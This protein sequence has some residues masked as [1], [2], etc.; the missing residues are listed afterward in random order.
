MCERVAGRRGLPARDPAARNH[1]TREHQAAFRWATRERRTGYDGE[2]TR[3][4]PDTRRRRRRLG[5]GLRDS[6]CRRSAAAGAQRPHLPDRLTGR[7]RGRAPLRAAHRAVTHFDPAPQGALNGLADARGARH[8]ASFHVPARA[9][10]HARAGAVSPRNE[11]QRSERV[12]YVECR[13]M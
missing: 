1:R 13:V 3:G 12:D 10:R 11:A 7:A 6:D 2:T 5:L 4:A 8:I 9:R